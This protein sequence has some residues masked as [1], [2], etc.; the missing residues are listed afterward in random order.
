MRGNAHPS[1]ELGQNQ[2]TPQDVRST[3][4]Q[5]AAKQTPLPGD[6]PELPNDEDSSAD[7]EAEA[8]L[9]AASPQKPRPVK[10]AL[11]NKYPRFNH[12]TGKLVTYSAKRKANGPFTE[13]NQKSINSK[14]VA[15]NR[16]DEPQLNKTYTFSNLFDLKS[17]D[18]ADFTADD[19][20]FK[21]KSEFRDIVKNRGELL[22][23]A[24]VALFDEQERVDQQNHVLRQQRS[25]SLKEIVNLNDKVQTLLDDKDNLEDKIQEVEKIGL[26]RADEV[27][28]A[29][30][31]FDSLTRLLHDANTDKLNARRNLS[32]TQ[33]RL[34]MATESR[35][36]LQ[37][38]I[39]ALNAKLIRAETQ[40]QR[41]QSVHFDATQ[42]Q[43]TS[44]L[45]RNRD[46]FDGR[47]RPTSTEL[48]G[49]YNERQVPEVPHH[50]RPSSSNGR[51]LNA[52]AL[53]RSGGGDGG[54]SGHPNDSHFGGSSNRFPGGAGPPGEPRRGPPGPPG[55]PDDGPTYPG[56]NS[57]FTSG[58]SIRRSTKDPHKKFFGS[59]DDRKN[60]EAWSFEIH[61][62]LIEDSAYWAK[63]TASV[64]N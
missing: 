26:Q 23:A 1:V 6:Y 49:L 52:P 42:P 60:Y 40:P 14:P 63:N 31:K 57:Q 38:R 53:G 8:E 59:E 24:V 10:R 18:L 5:K 21:N 15:L 41:Q 43:P 39:E 37:G 34:R 22:F 30:Q 48:N 20:T 56:S 27:A 36:G 2:Y 44:V 54:G 4:Y 55:P 51:G 32:S 62:I 29:N 12:F 9:D 13:E 7:E 3:A 16:V 61:H 58:G 11:F 50:S 46:A 35:E 19:F 25:Y 47:V 33:D 28:E 64:V 17:A 45:N